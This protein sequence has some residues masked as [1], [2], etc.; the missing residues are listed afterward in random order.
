MIRVCATEQ[1]PENQMKEVAIG[2]GSKVLILNSGGQ[3][4]AYQAVCPHQEVA[5]CEGIFDGCT[6]TCHEHLW[7][8]DATTGA[9]IGLAEAP[10]EYFDVEIKDGDIYVGTPNAL[11]LASIFEGVAD[12]V[13]GRLTDLMRV[14]T[15]PAGSQIYAAGDPAT[16]LYILE[17]GRVAFMLGSDDRTSPGGFIVRKGELFGW[18]ALSGDGAKRIA[19]A[20]CEDESTVIELDGSAVLTILKDS[21]EDGLRVMGNLVQLITRYFASF[22]GQ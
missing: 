3:Y 19:R 18:A 21:P 13:L 2:E 16:D 1:V 10:L 15:Y 4:F 20:T 22:G 7:Q 6:L 5:L 11:K 8:W 14:T 12:D 9:P 17:K